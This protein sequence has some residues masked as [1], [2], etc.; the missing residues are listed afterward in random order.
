MPEIPTRQ[1]ILLVI[2]FVSLSY[3]VYDYFLKGDGQPAPQRPANQNVGQI[4]TP[5]PIQQRPANNISANVQANRQ[6]EGQ[7]NRQ[8]GDSLE[9]LKY[10]GTWKNDPFF[11]SMAVKM[12]INKAATN[13]A[14]NP[15]EKLNYTGFIKHQGRMQA[16]INGFQ[17]IE[18]QEI[19]DFLIEKIEEYR[20]IVLSKTDGKKYTLK[21]NA[22]GKQ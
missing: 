9:I 16:T 12:N 13:V 11:R 10:S 17:Y 4:G 1:K 15:A 19:E 6:A 5:Q 21:L 20:V 8:P 22:G 14:A 3:L 7:E 18:G 2:M